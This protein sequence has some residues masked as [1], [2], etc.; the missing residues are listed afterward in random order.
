[1]GLGKFTAL[2]GMGT[3]FLQI[4][5]ISA[6]SVGS[7]ITLLKQGLPLRIS[8]RQFR[9]KNFGYCCED[10]YLHLFN[11]GGVLCFMLLVPRTV[12]SRETPAG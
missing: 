12:F 8:L 7:G 9:L 10:E 5:V 11:G 3:Q 2:C 6:S 4:A 1:M